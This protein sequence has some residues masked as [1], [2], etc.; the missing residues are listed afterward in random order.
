MVDPPT[1]NNTQSCGIDYP[2][3]K[4]VMLPISINLFLIAWPILRTCGVSIPHELAGLLCLGDDGSGPGERKINER[5]T[6]VCFLFWGGCKFD[7]LPFRAS[8]G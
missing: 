3:T 8:G 7:R 2:E 4:P 6:G 1:S 5:I